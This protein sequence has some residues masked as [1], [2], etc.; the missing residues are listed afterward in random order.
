MKVRLNAVVVVTDKITNYSKFDQ[1]SSDEES[2]SEIF[3]DAG[4]YA[5]A[6]L[7]TARTVACGSATEK[8]IF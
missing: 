4:K 3:Y 8:M 1:I 2:E 7:N 5:I 6:H